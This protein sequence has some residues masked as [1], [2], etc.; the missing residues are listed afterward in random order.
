MENFSVKKKTDSSVT[1]PS[2]D[3]AF[4]VHQELSAFDQRKS[5]TLKK[6]SSFA[7]VVAKDN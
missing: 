1:E 4:P 7:D 6:P 2:A 3:R 5:S